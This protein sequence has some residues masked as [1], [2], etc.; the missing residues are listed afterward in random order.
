MPKDIGKDVESRL[1]LN[2]RVLLTCWPFVGHISPFMSVA[3]A[4]KQRGIDVALYTGETV[5]NSVSAEGIAFFPFRHV[6]E[7]HAYDLV[8]RMDVAGPTVRP[9]ISEVASTFREWFA[10]TIPSQI[11]D[12]EPLIEE[13]QPDVIVTETAMWGPVVVLWE[14]TGIPVVMLSTM[15]GSLIPG[16][17]APVSALGKPPPASI[18]ARVLASLVNSI[19]AVAGRPMRNRIDE[20]RAGFALAPLGCS[21]NEFTG[22]LPLYLVGN[23]PEFDFNRTDLPETVKYVG[24]LQWRRMEASS[25]TSWL[26]S[27]PSGRPWVHVTE[28]TLRYGEPFVLK[29]ASDGMNDGAYE[30]IMTSGAH[31]QIDSMT[32]DGGSQHVHVAQWINHDDLLSRCA[33]LVSTGGAGT[34]MAGVLAG[35][36][37]VVVPTAWDKPDNALR[38]AESGAGIRLAARDCTPDKLRTAVDTVIRDPAYAEN[39]RRLRDLL[40]SAPGPSGA[41]DLIIELLNRERVGRV[42]KEL[43]ELQSR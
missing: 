30:V 34:I 39:A 28:S 27:I 14:R 15:L 26:Q 18:P 20:I 9:K 3:L 31:R 17:G 12:L 10:E 32:G 35:I 22:R 7:S 29:A 37:Q 6:D 8:A 38:V 13:W 11:A 43:S 4:L 1:C 25:D 23:V 41:A 36:P 16:P 21:V 42:G 2:A 19:S 24:P 33:A 40:R 5:G